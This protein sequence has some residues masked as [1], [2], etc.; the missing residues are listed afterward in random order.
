MRLKKYTVITI[1]LAGLFMVNACSDLLDK[2]PESNLS[3]AVYWQ[4][5]ADFTQAANALYKSS[6]TP[7][8]A[9]VSPLYADRMSDNAISTSSDDISSG[10]H[11][12]SSNFGPWNR[13]Y[14]LIRSSNIILEQAER[15]DLTPDEL[16]IPTA[17]ARF[18][19]AFAYAD[20]VR[21]YGDVPLIL[22]SLDIGDD[23]LYDSRTPRETVINQIY[24]DLDYAAANLPPVSDEVDEVAYGKVSSGTALAFK[25]RVALREGTWNKFHGE[26]TGANHLEVARNAAQDVMQSGDYSLYEEF[27]SDSYWRLFKTSAEGPDNEEAIW[28]VIHGFNSSDD[29]ARNQ[30]R[31]LPQGTMAGTRSLIDSYLSADGLPI[32]QSDLYQEQQNVESEYQDRDPRLDGSIIKPGDTYFN[33][34]TP[35]IPQLAAIT[36]YHVEKYYDD[37]GTSNYLDFMLIRYA[38]VLL[39]Y[40]EAVYELNDAI[41]DDQLNSS[42][43]LLRDRV[44]MPHLTNAF[45]A[46][47]DL[48]MREEI[49]RERRVELAFEG[50]RYDDLL[51]WKIAEDEL[52]EAI[53]GARFFNAEYPADDPST[54][55]LTPDSLIIAQPAS[56]RNFEPE[57][58]YLWPLPLNELGLNSNLEQNPGW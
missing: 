43:N 6:Y 54:L 5:E 41:T 47:N 44:G 26:G 17:E 1:S 28:V 23:E 57:K 19:R 12:P 13:R 53:L 56:Q 38:E 10:N 20:L 52:P 27:G 45:V 24:E 31:V 51:R 7:M 36:G 11:I 48:N 42:I 8:G 14:S 16:L 29:V 37:E 4:N 3:D 32:D 18:F 22:K 46:E 39:N 34:F 49:R 40:A 55:S 9:D 33:T 2:V 35:Y 30:G 25:S 15:S 21:R 50:F 58:H